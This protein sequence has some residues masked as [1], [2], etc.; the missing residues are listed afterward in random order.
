MA[1][2]RGVSSTPDEHL[3][4]YQLH[5]RY[6]I[7]AGM[8]MTAA[9]DLWLEM[10]DTH[11][12]R[13]NHMSALLARLGPLTVPSSADSA[14]D[15]AVSEGQEY[16][17]EAKRRRRDGTQTRLRLEVDGFQCQH[18]GFRAPSKVCTSTEEAELGAA[19]VE[20]HH[21][22]P[23]QEGERQTRLED[24]ITLCPTCH[25]LLHAI[26]RALRS[27]RLSIDVLRSCL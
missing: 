19:V 2:S 26:G 23:L 21:I 5:C 4:L 15:A 20:V 9:A 24:L 13:V 3:T 16:L 11:G 14:F 22:D 6:A 7:L 12:S 10:K 1:S 18:C 8:N 17:E 25:R 27:E